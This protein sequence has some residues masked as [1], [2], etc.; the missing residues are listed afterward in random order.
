M[1][2]RYFF[3][4]IPT[5]SAPNKVRLFDYS[6]TSQLID[7]QNG[8]QHRDLQYHIQLPICDV[9]FFDQQIKNNFQRIARYNFHFTDHPLTKPFDSL[10]FLPYIGP[11]FITGITSSSKNHQSKFKSYTGIDLPF[12]LD[13][14]TKAAFDIAI[15]MTV[16]T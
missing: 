16:I 8:I 5:H 6:Q 7:Y 12:L 3:Q 10:F 4:N 15:K 11:F 14:S 9:L 13:I 1:Q 2:R